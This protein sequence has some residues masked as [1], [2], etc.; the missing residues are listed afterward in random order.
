M[1]PPLTVS[2]LFTQTRLAHWLV[3]ALLLAAGVYLYGVG[4]LRRRGDHWPVSRSVL[5]LGAGLGSIAAVTIGGVGA[6]ETSLLSV[7]VV[8]HMVLGM[9]APIFLA[10]GAPVTLAL[11]V[12]PQTPRRRLLALLRSRV[13]R[14][15][16]FPLFA[17]GLFVVTPFALYFTDLYR[18][19]LENAFAREMM[20]VHFIVTGCLFFWPLVGIDPLPSRWHYPARALLMLLS[21]PFH[22]VLGLTI[23]QGS[24]LLGGDW[25]P[26]LQLGWADPWVD[27]KIAG[28][29]L[30]AS[31]ELV[32]VIMLFV[33][34]VQW[35]RHSE[36][37]ARRI[38]RELDR[39]E[40]REQAAGSSAPA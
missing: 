39:Q 6:Y 21:V 10:L 5:F 11:R 3:G 25:Y 38:D 34:A 28:G 19:T 33:L 40:A 23:M 13:A 22:T 9:I 2:T 18:V 37:E 32:S 26:A 15:L 24:T 30:W 29:I 8:Q 14:V 35:M 4:R 12:L 20:G 16:F 1:L 17:Y 7:R 31:G 27:Q 36:R